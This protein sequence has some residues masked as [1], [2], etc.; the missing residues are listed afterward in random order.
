MQ[1][2]WSHDTATLFTDKTKDQSEEECPKAVGPHQIEVPQ[3]RIEGSQNMP[4][5]EEQ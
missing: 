5:S 3:D 1:D 4:K 2:G